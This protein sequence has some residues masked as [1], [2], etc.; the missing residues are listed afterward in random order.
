MA[1]A[2]V[3]AAVRTTEP[4]TTSMGLKTAHDLLRAVIPEWR[5]G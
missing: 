1:S 3:T 4:G 5:L 2:E